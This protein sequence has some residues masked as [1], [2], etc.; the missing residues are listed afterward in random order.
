MFRIEWD[1]EK[2]KKNARLHGIDFIEL[3]EL[4]DCETYTVLDERFEYNEIR[5]L[6]L[7][8]L[9]GRVIAVSHTE[10]DDVIRIISARKA[11]KHEQETYFTKIRD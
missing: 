6:T 9:N 11:E 2:R 8:M 3:Q 5:F 10:T 4:F 7:G 1:E